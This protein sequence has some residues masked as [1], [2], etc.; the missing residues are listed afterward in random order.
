MAIEA[1][2]SRYKRNNFKLYILVCLV[3]GGWFAYDGY[4]S[5]SFIA[6]HTDEQGNADGILV[7]NRKAP[8]VFAALAVFI[9]AYFYVVKDRKVV[10]DDKELVVAGKT[11]IPY[12]AIEAI[13]KTHFEQ[14]GAFTIV[15]K[16][17]G[18]G[19]S[20]HRLTDRQYDNLGLILEHLVAQIT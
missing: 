6:E 18:G 10:A 11:R 19:E 8:P 9:G 2:L 4:I 7:L 12:D 17:P 3:L 20:R 5:K 14:K 16:N 1:P 15:Y 13:D